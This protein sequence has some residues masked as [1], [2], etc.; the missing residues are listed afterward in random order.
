L[1]DNKSKLCPYCGEDIK[2]MAIKCK[3]C[4]SMLADI[5][6]QV[7]YADALTEKPTWEQKV[8]HI[9]KKTSRAGAWWTIFISVPLAPILGLFLFGVEG[10]KWGAGIGV[11][12]FIGALV[13]LL[14]KD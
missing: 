13:E 2:V 4:H 14:K 10:L 11:L 9:G 1:D 5:G 3:H 6:Q 8:K 7:Q 12:L